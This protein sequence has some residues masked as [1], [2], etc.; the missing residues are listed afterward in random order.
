M[1]L[2][3]WVDITPLVFLQ[4]Q[5]QAL[6]SQAFIQHTNLRV[7]EP[8]H[9]C[10]KSRHF[11]SSPNA[12]LSRV[13]PAGT[14]AEGWR[15]CLVLSCTVQGVARGSLGY[16]VPHCFGLLSWMYRH[17]NSELWLR[18]ILFQ[19]VICVEVEHC[20]YNPYCYHLFHAVLS[21]MWGFFFISSNFI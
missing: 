9:L 17:V 13:R 4:M 15:K 6:K 16:R 20:C 10:P 11:L 8:I 18:S 3:W 5:K 14:W 21:G 7:P 1:G 12:I 2:P 19:L